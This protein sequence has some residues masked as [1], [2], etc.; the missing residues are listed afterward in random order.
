M[1]YHISSLSLELPLLSFG[2]NLR[3]RG[4]TCC[5]IQFPIVHAVHAHHIV[6][7]GIVEFR[8]FYYLC[9]VKL[10]H[11]AKISC[12]IWESPKGLYFFFGVVV[13]FFWVVVAIICSDNAADGSGSPG[14]PDGCRPPSR[15][16]CGSML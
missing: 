5:S 2:I 6:E 1:S 8:A 16:G 13:R 3:D 7:V 4:K 9:K 14:R 15:S 11:A 10:Q 12:G